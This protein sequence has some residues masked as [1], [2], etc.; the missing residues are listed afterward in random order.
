M[1]SAAR[2]ATLAICLCIGLLDAVKGNADPEPSRQACVS[3][4]L[5][6][7]LIGGVF[8][9]CLHGEMPCGPEGGP[10]VKTRETR[11]AID[12]TE[13]LKPD[14]TWVRA[15]GGDGGQT[16][17]DQNATVVRAILEPTSAPKDRGRIVLE[18]HSSVTPEQQTWREKVLCENWDA[19]VVYTTMVQ[20]LEALF[21]SGTRGARRMHQLA[22]AVLIFDEVQA[23]PIKCVHLFNNAINFLA[24]HCSTTVLLCTA[25]QPLLDRV[26]TKRGA[27]TLAPQ[28][29][30][31]HDVQGLFDQLERV[32]VNDQ[33][34]PGGWA[35]QEVADLALKEVSRD[36]SCLVIVNTKAAARS[37]FKLAREQ[38]DEAAIQHLSTDMCPAHRKQALARIRIRLDQKQP[39]LCVSTQLIEAGVDV[40]FRVVIRFLAGLDSIAQAAGRCNRN[41]APEPGVVHVVNPAE[42][43]LEKLPDILIGREKAKRVL[44]DYKDDPSRY[45]GN[46]VGPAALNDYYR[47][48]FFDRAHDMSYPFAA[49]D[50]GH[51]DTLLNLLA[52]N[53]QAVSH[54]AARK[55]AG[56]KLFFRQA[57]MTAAKAF[58][59]IDAPTQGV[60]VPHG[61]AGQKLIA[62]LYAAFDIEKQFKLLR[63]AQQYTVNVF[64]HMFEKLRDVGALHELKP[65]SDLR[66]F[67]LDQRYYSHQFGLSTE[68]VSRMESLHE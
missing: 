25:T 46:L 56:P 19:P 47:Y 65:G 54:Y 17:I 37:I 10:K 32:V 45:R 50:V 14:N 66:I 7:G 11:V 44:D 48:Y 60:V 53:E 16:V 49:K 67:C 22:N 2:R 43:N 3:Q 57:F 52:A 13:F 23:L 39:T 59:A 63:A 12:S 4:N 35:H 41:G 61:K 24:H 40:D 26:S 27:V 18:H 42:E 15:V 64:P 28:H 21:G 31:M 51:D 36:G 20:F 29:E 34:R 62:D 58:K 5:L 55:Q 9:S 38:L 8:E 30:L 1:T 68:P 33:R 6:I